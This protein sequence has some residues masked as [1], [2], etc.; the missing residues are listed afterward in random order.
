[1]RCNGKV[2]RT[3]EVE[4][5]LYPSWNAT[6]IFQEGDKTLLDGKFQLKEQRKILGII[7]GGR[8]VGEGEITIKK[9][10]LI[11]DTHSVYIR[12]IRNRQLA[13]VAKLQ[14]KVQK[15]YSDLGRA[16]DENLSLFSHGSSTVLE[17]LRSN[18]QRGAKRRLGDIEEEAE[19]ELD[20]PQKD[21]E[22]KLQPLKNDEIEERGKSGDKFEERIDMV[23]SEKDEK[24]NQ[25]DE[26]NETKQEIKFEK[27][28][29]AEENL[30]IVKI[31]GEEGKSKE[32]IKQETKAE[33]KQKMMKDIV[34]TI[35]SEKDM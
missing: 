18:R 11:A 17:K 1:M 9:G 23:K 35:M 29:K 20:L 34:G 26:K 28:K 31:N 32:K 25:E 12:N 4:H 14:I 15:L 8:Q 3:L 24:K 10:E 7:V 13:I 6:F 22:E 19:D 21:K 2:C 16:K 5:G 30:G 33:T 27:E